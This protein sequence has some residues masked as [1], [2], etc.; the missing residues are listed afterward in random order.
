MGPRED[1]AERPCR[2]FLEGVTLLDLDG[3]KWDL[4]SGPSDSLCVFFKIWLLGARIPASP[5][6]WP[7]GA[8]R[9]G[10][11]GNVSP[12]GEDLIS[13]SPRYP[14]VPACCL[15][16]RSRASAHAQSLGRPGKATAG[17]R[18]HFPVCLVLARGSTGVVVRPLLWS[19]YIDRQDVGCGCH[20][21]AP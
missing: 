12:H 6:N 11:D 3:R 19:S 18:L 16:F 14:A 1:E 17:S 15:H 13:G 8:P 20:R 10:V 5:T 7:C 2:S 21:Y 4:R 9:V